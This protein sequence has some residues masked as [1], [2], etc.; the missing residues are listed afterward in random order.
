VTAMQRRMD[1]DAIQQRR[2]DLATDLDALHT[3]WPTLFHRMQDFVATLP[4]H[5]ATMR[6]IAASLDHP[7]LVSAVDQDDLFSLDAPL[8]L[9]HQLAN[10]RLA[11]LPGNRHA[12]QALDLDLLASTL[13]RHFDEDR[14]NETPPS[15]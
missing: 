2:P 10:S 5:S 9:H 1:V 14:A 8:Q 6:Q 15:A 12:L 3:D 7:T 4:A 13:R 11:I